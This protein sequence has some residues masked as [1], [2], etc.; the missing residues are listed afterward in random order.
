MDEVH[1]LGFIFHCMICTLLEL[2]GGQRQRG[3]LLGKAK[4]IEGEREREGM[5]AGLQP[6]AFVPT[7][8]YCG[9]Q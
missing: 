9:N 1:F 2:T 7:V 5:N 6:S 8:G 4:A 3:K